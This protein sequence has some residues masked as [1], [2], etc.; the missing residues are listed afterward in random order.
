M[1]A[2]AAGMIAALAVGWALYKKPEVSLVL[3]AS[4]AGLVAVT[5]GAWGT[6]A[7]GIFG[8]MELLGTGLSRGAQILVQ[9]EGIVAT[10]A[11]A[12]P[13]ALAFFLPHD[14]LSPIRVNPADEEAGFN[15][16][17]HEVSTEIN[18]RFT[19]KDEQAESGDLS[20]RAPVSSGDD[21]FN[22][23]RPEYLG[24]VLAGFVGSVHRQKYTVPGD[25]VN[26][27]SRLEALTRRCPDKVL[28]DELTY[29][30]V[31]G[32]IGEVRAYRSRVRGKSR[33][34]TLYGIMP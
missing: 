26:V 16:A 15:L 23:V 18:G 11:A 7:V 31:K 32:R 34:M 25:P 17:E 30:L 6:V 29:R 14:K 28:M 2:G 21:A 10:G 9:L 27:A 20:P 33:P 8:K 12:F 1:L 13:L 22:D 4:L 24:Q 3:N 5:A 19:T